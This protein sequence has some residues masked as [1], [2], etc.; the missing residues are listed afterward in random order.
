MQALHAAILLSLCCGLSHFL[1]DSDALIF[2][3]RLGIHS[4]IKQSQMVRQF[5]EQNGVIDV[6][7][8]GGQVNHQADVAVVDAL[9]A[10]TEN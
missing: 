1:Y 3:Q 4:Q 2:P 7:R 6:R 10:P 8:Q 9:L 5:I